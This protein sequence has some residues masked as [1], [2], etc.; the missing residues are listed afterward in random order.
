MIKPL[1]FKEGDQFIWELARF[2][3]TVKN[4]DCLTVVK[5]E[6]GE[7]RFKDKQG[8]WFSSPDDFNDW[9]HCKKIED[10]YE[11]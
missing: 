5:D 4:T 9:K 10:Y 11:K 2:F 1:K 6:E 8:C 3:K 7:L